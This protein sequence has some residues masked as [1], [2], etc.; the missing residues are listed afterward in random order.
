VAEEERAQA[1]AEE[2]GVSGWEEAAAEG[3]EPA[4]ARVEEEE[5]AGEA[6]AQ[7][8]RRQACC[9]AGEAG[10]GPAQ[11]SGSSCAWLPCRVRQTRSL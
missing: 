2:E 11:R 10:Y 3:R 7:N 8:F 1:E 6:S 4:E 5:E 9:S